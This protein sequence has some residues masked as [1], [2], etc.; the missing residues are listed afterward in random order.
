MPLYGHTTFCSP[1]TNWQASELLPLW[2]CCRQ[3]CC[4]PVYSN[5]SFQ[6]FIFHPQASSLRQ[7]TVELWS[8]KELPSCSPI[9]ILKSPAQGPTLS[10]SLLTF[11]FCCLLGSCGPALD[12]LLC[13]QVSPDDMSLQR[14]HKGGLETAH[15]A[16]PSPN[17]QSNSFKESQRQLQPACHSQTP[18]PSLQGCSLCGHTKQTPQ[19]STPKQQL[20]HLGLK[21]AA[22]E[23]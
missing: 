23:F 20:S 15:S 22:A 11:V 14:A 10:T 13:Y 3:C 1:V 17:I 19:D 21:V 16:L 7:G 12:R 6:V 4:N 9:R 18:S 2:G 5:L 8:L